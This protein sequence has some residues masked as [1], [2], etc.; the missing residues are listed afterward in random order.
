MTT[1]ILLHVTLCCFLLVLATQGKNDTLDLAVVLDFN[2][3]IARCKSNSSRIISNAPLQLVINNVTVS[4]TGRTTST[5]MILS[6]AVN[7][8]SSEQLA[9]L[10]SN[11]G[12]FLVAPP[13]AC[14]APSIPPDQRV[15]TPVHAHPLTIGP[16][17]LVQGQTTTI[18]AVVDKFACLIGFIPI[19]LN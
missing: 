8:T 19:S 10:T 3:T 1:K 9:S 4:D 11:G 13:H 6:M 12:A 17:G 15:A 16:A 5:G 7:L 2:G 14:G 18:A